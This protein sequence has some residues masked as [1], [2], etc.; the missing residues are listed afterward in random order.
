M[1]FINIFH[2]FSEKIRLDVS[3]ESSSRQR[4]HM[5]I[6]SL[7]SSK[8]KKKK[9]N[10]PLLHFLFGTLRVNRIYDGVEAETRKSR[11]VFRLLSLMVGLPSM[12]L[13]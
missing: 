1:T 5:N 10:C 9:L 12:Q 11:V 13:K 8:D 3:S 7:F 4:I 6:Q 2:C